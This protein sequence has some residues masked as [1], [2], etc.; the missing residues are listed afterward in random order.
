M[1]DNQI[2]DD[3]IKTD[4]DLPY[5][6]SFRTYL[7]EGYKLG[8]ANFPI[9]F[10]LHG[11][12]ERGNNLDLV[13]T[14]GIP[15]LI[16]NNKRFP[17]ITVAPQCPLFEWWSRPEMTNSLINL[18]EKV[19]QTYKA[20]KSRIYLSGMS[21]GGYGSIAL[22]NKRPD[23][24]AAMISVCGGADFDN[25]ENLTKLPIWLFH[26]SE[27]DVHPASRSE[28]I[29]NQLKDINPDIKLTIYDGIDHNSWDI[30][31]DNDDIYDWLL[32]KNK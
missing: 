20:D 19:I 29:Y 3:I 4:V 13:E 31:F 17:F 27:D 23:L 24:F 25:F 18:V 9:V 32:S 5:E 1:N 21:M 15:K 12:G 22:A 28:K 2:L 30:T 8:N 7:P 26:G 6:I 16:K 14:H 10:F 11:V